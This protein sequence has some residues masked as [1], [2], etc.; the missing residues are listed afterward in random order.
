M[1]WGFAPLSA[2]G[3]FRFRLSAFGLT[4]FGRLA[5][6]APGSVS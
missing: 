2:F 3:Y 6:A 4:R 1:I 5:Y